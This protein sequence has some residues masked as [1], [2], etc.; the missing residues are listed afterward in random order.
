M[1]TKKLVVFGLGQRGGIY[2]AFAKAYPEKFQ[3]V[4]IIENDEQRIG[5]AK[6]EYPGTR[7]FENYQDFLK[8]KIPA[9]IV[10]VA[11]QDEAHREHAIAMMAAGCDLLL[12]KPIANNPSDCMDIY[13][14]GKRYGRKAVVCHVLRYTPFYST[15]KKIIDSGKLGEIVTVHASENVGYYHQAHS[16]VRGPWRNKAQ[17]SPMILAKCCHDMDILRYLIGEECQSVSSYGGLKYFHLGNAPEGSTQYCSECPHTDCVFKAQTIY[18]SPQGRFFSN[19]FSVREKT[20]ENILEDLQKTQYDR[21]VFRCDND[22]V[23]HQVTILQFANGKTA[24]HTMPAF[25]KEIYR[26]LKIHGTKAELV[27]CVEENA[28]EIRYV[29]GEVEKIAI[30]VSAANVG[31]HMGGDYYMMNSLFKTLNGEVADG[32]TYLDVSI[33]SHL[34]SFA[35]EESRLNG[36]N[37]VKIEK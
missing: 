9:D 22:V 25:S 27:G 2:A 13:N 34:M 33:E 31:G 6:K 16:F 18:T 5:Y 32:I 20:D 37:A 14:A 23:D 26:D 19:Y 12:E 3:L 10:A 1:Q 21:C 29:G 36:G 15:V 8:E 24:C 28:L 30:D 7:L 11:T 17:S 35:A 4:A